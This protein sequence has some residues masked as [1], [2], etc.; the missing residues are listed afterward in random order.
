MSLLDE[1][2][3]DLAIKN[4]QKKPESLIQLLTKKVDGVTGYDLISDQLENLDATVF[5]HSS[6]FCA[7]VYI[8]ME[9]IYL[10]A[11]YTVPQ[12]LY[13]SR[14]KNLV[15]NGVD[16]TSPDV[17]ESRCPQ[18]YDSIFINFSK[19]LKEL[20]LEKDYSSQINLLG[21]YKEH[22]NDNLWEAK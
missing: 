1:A 4:E 7:R 20:I 3:R 12:L 19:L 17:L 13:I 16:F 18:K 5:T 22:K 15:E 21:Y 2:L 11:A 6:G 10:S 14:D 8:G 9:P